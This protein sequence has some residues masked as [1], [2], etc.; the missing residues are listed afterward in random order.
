VHQVCH[1]YGSAA[2]PIA[3]VA[4]V[5]LL[6]TAVFL[7]KPGQLVSHLILSLFSHYLFEDNDIHATFLWVSVKNDFTSMT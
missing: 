6:L 1:G 3:Q 7:L 2:K 4:A 5:H